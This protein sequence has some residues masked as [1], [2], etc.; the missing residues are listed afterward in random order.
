M[1]INHYVDPNINPKLDLYCKLLDCQN[2]TVDDLDCQNLTVDNFLTFNTL[3]VDNSTIEINTVNNTIPEISS[4]N[5]DLFVL[6]TQNLTNTGTA[7]TG[8][9]RA[10]KGVYNVLESNSYLN[11]TDIVNYGVVFTP[12]KNIITPVD[13]QNWRLSITP[14][15]KTL[16]QGLFVTSTVYSIKGNCSFIATPAYEDYY[17]EFKIDLP[18]VSASSQEI[19]A[20]GLAQS[21]LSEIVSQYALTNCSINPSGEL[22]LQYFLQLNNANFPANL[23]IYFEFDLSVI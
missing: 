16:E 17:I 3:K 19:A 13:L 21:Q 2:L 6:S 10:T 11:Y 9:V 14:I 8:L 22:V 7:N 5:L 12:T 4:T 1:S 18:F 15:E 20:I 23:P